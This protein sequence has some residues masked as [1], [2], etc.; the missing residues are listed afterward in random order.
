MF[1][2][3]GSRSLIPQTIASTSPENL[4]KLSRYLR[5]FGDSDI[6]AV[7]EPLLHRAIFIFINQLRLAWSFGVML[8]ASELSIVNDRNPT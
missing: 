5:P 6:A 7:C 4:G 1:V 2:S 3:N 8:Y